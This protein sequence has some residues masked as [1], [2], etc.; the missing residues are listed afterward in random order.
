MACCCSICVIKSALGTCCCQ[1]NISKAL[2]TCCQ[3]GK[4][5][6]CLSMSTVNPTP[7]ICQNPMGK[8][9]SAAS[10]FMCAMKSVANYGSTLVGALSGAG[11][12]AV[13]PSGIVK[14]KVSG[15]GVATPVTSNNTMMLIIAGVVVFFLVLYLADQ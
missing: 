1:S 8:S 15:A 10:S 6:C 12:C 7:G 3:A 5:S 13:T 9:Q 4:A 14:A 2:G 11:S